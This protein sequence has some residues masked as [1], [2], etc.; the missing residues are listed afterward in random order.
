MIVSMLVKQQASPTVKTQ[1]HDDLI[2]LRDLVEAEKITPVIDGTYPLDQTPQAIAR[3]AAGHTR[4][5]IVITVV[6]RER[7]R[8]AAGHPNNAIRTALPATS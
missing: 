5:T 6:P 8:V 7:D 1:N 2:A 4:G 3:V